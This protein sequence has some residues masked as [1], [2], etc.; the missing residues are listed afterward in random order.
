MG[1]E[2]VNCGCGGKAV[3]VAEPRDGYTSY[4]C[5]CLECA[6]NTD[7]YSTEVEAATAWNRSIGAT[8]MNVEN[9]FVKDMNVPNKEIVIIEPLTT[10][11]DYIGYCMC[12][13]L[14][15]TNWKYCPECGREIQWSVHYE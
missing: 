1:K 14:V 4:Y 2:L 7:Y 13:N 5:T 15:N 11:I 9:K 6:I 3:V 8:D 10:G 12:G